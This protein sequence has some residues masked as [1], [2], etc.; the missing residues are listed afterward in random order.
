MSRYCENC[1]LFEGGIPNTKKQVNCSHSCWKET[2]ERHAFI[3]D[4]SI[5]LWLKDKATQTNKPMSYWVE[6]AL[7]DMKLKDDILA[8][9]KGRI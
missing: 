3:F 9:R 8:Q 7:I 2:K 6:L 1:K 4:Q 5:M